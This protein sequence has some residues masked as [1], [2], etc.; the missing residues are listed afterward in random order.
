M[1]SEKAVGR[2]PHCRQEPAQP[3]RSLPRR[4]NLFLS[5]LDDAERRWYAA[6]ESSRIGHGDDRLRS[7][8][9]GWRPRRGRCAGDA[10][11]HGA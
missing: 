2:C 9:T 11:A 7:P 8:L 3:D 10:H 1:P 4:L 5:R 6:P